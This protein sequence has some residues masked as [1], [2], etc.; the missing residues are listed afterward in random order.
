MR[1]DFFGVA[2]E[3]PRVTFY[4]WSPWRASALEHRLFEVVR[5]LPRTEFEEAPDELRVHMPDPKTWKS[6]LQA[7]AR[8][9]KGWQEE[10]DPGRE[11]RSWE[12]LIE[13]DSNADGY[14]HYGEPFSLWMFLRISLDMG[15]IGEP[16]RGEDI[17]LHGFGIRICGEEGNGGN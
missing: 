13:G 3:T 11:R 17:D 6:A 2:F 16:D 14:D 7:I 8:V 9:L 15:G 5:A 4:L 1:I 10:G 12:W